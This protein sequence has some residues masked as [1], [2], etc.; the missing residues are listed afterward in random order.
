MASVFFLQQ[1]SDLV[2]QQA[3]FLA[4]FVVVVVVEVAAGLSVSVPVLFL[5]AGSGVAV[6]TTGFGLLTGTLPVADVWAELTTM[7]ATKNAMDKTNF[8]MIFIF[9]YILNVQ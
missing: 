7:N 4:F 3:F 8:F 2:W 5:T 6:C 1:A 9:K